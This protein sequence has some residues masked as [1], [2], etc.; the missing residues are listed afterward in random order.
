MLDSQR[1]SYTRWD[2]LGPG[3][4]GRQ[5]EQQW[6]ALPGGRPLRGRRRPTGTTTWASGLPEFRLAV[7]QAGV[8]A[9]QVA[10]AVERS[11]TEPRPV[12]PER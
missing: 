5:L 2:G 9:R 8:P 4:P 10:S 1:A 6:P 3:G 12:E 11:G 7:E